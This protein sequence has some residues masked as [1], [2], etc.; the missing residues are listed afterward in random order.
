ML[1]RPDDR[2]ARLAEDFETHQGR[3]QPMTWDDLPGVV[4]WCLWLCALAAIAIATSLLALLVLN[5]S[6]GSAAVLADPLAGA[7]W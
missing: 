5:L 7:P 6:L 4:Q 2:A 1:D 3:I